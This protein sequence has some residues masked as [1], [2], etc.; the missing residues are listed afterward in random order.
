MSRHIRVKKPE[1]PL[2]LDLIDEWQGDT[3][4]ACTCYSIHTFN[5]VCHALR[6]AGVPYKIIEVIDE[7]GEPKAWNQRRKKR[8]IE[9]K[10]RPEET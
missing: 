8:R 1:N 5:A 4:Y 7:N 6:A 9:G 3:I 2:P 10:Y